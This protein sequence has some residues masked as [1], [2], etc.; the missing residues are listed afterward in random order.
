MK[1]ATNKRY[2]II[3]ILQAIARDPA[4]PGYRV[5]AAKD[6]VRALKKQS[7][8]YRYKSFEDLLNHWYFTLPA[9]LG[10]PELSLRQ[11]SSPDVQRALADSLVA[12][13]I[14]YNI[15]LEDTG[16]W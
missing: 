5:T 15:P 11:V 9:A 10:W 7:N 16:G 8:R 4:T 12:R 1:K 14:L 6:L 13:A 3:K 2:R